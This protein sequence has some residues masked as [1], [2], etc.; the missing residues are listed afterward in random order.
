[1]NFIQRNPNDPQYSEYHNGEYEYWPTDSAVKSN[2]IRIPAAVISGLELLA[3]AAAAVVLMAVSMSTLYATFAPRAIGEYS[4]VINTNIHN[5][6]SDELIQYLL[7]PAA[8]PEIICQEGTLPEDENILRL[9]NL[10]R[11][12][13]YLLHLYDQEQNK[14]GEF[15]FTT[16]GD[17]PGGEPPQSSAPVQPPEDGPAPVDPPAETAATE[18]DSTEE[19]TEPVTEPETEPTEP[20]VRPVTPPPVIYDP[21]PAPQPDPQPEPPPAPQPTVPPET[22]PEEP[23]DPVAMDP[24][25][26]FRYVPNESG[27]VEGS[28]FEYTDVHTFENVP[29]DYTVVVMVDGEATEAYTADYTNGTLKI[30]LDQTVVFTGTKSTTT[31]TVTTGDGTVVESTSKFAPPILDRSNVTLTAGEN[32]SGG[33]DFRVIAPV[34]PEDAEEMT[35]RAVLYVEDLDSNL[36]AQKEIQLIKDAGADIYQNICYVPEA[37]APVIVSAEIHGSWKKNGEIQY[38]ELYIVNE[39]FGE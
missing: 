39:Y 20:A 23:S 35:C 4:V 17:S 15:E 30:T 31:V 1:M 22:E 28:Y 34:L 25:P 12:T 24:E 26:I 32:S 8:D 7:S 38:E 3:A 9:L 13:T 29:A 27:T 6:F 2:K 5:N 33:Y 36:I 18:P 11:A 21:D 19:T 37:E 16:S 10:K 14:I